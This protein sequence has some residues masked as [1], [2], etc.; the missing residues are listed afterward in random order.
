M[1][2]VAS[3]HHVEKNG[4]L[5]GG[6]RGRRVKPVWLPVHLEDA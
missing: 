1:L 3:G 4:A 6:K 2:A 5:G